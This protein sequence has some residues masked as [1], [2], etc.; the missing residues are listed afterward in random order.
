MRFIGALIVFVLAGLAF[1]WCA[2]EIAVQTLGRETTAHVDSVLKSSGYRRTTYTAHYEF[3][4]ED[5]SKGY[6]SCPSHRGATGGSVRVRYLRHDPSFNT[7]AVWWYA[8]FWML[9]FGAPAWPLALSSARLLLYRRIRRFDDPEEDDEDKE[10]AEAEDTKPAEAPPTAP[11]PVADIEPVP[12]R[13]RWSAAILFSLVLSAAAIA[14]N[15]ALFDLRE[16]AFT[17]GQVVAL[18]PSPPRDA[19]APPPAP[20]AALPRGASVGNTANDSL[21]GFDGDALYYG[22][23]RN[24]DDPSAPPPG[25]YRFAL[26]GTGRTLIGKPGQTERIYRGVQVKDDWIYYISMD[27]IC[28]IRKDGTRHDL[29]TD[30][31][32]SSMAVVGDWIY[33]QHSVLDGAIFCMHLDGGGGKQLCREAVGTMCVADDGWIY[34]AN[35]TDGGR[36]WRMKT[37]GTARAR[38]ADR[39]V[40]A[41]LV[42]GDTIWFADAGGKPAL[43]RMNTNGAGGE[44]VVDDTALAINWADGRV[45]FCRGSGELARC[46]PDGSGLEGVAPAASSVLIHKGHLFIHPDIEAKTLQ[47]ANLDGSD[48][49]ELR[50]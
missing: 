9:A 22:L 12:F 2:G 36:L 43:C 10:D 40:G 38:L 3:T 21:L 32:V 31:R 50:F 34:Y 6:G 46:K 47:R 24:Y 49:R 11:A 19:S 30:S 14:C 23:W 7:P 17:L 20:S 45:Y 4:T 29:L 39:R 5:M 27:G 33:Y 26:D 25:L 35:K 28:R 41:L 37:D 13:N 42:V 16:K 48:L 1:R 44:V 8:G 18:P 15:L